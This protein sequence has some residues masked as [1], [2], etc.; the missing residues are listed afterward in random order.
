MTPE[1]VEDWVES[2]R[3]TARFHPW[4]I[5]RS[6]ASI[7]GF[8]KAAPHRSREAYRWSAEVSAYIDP[9]FH[10]RGVGSALYGVLIPL[11]RAQGYVTLLAG[12]T[13]GHEASERLHAK[14]GFVRCGT[15][16]RIGWKLDRWQDVG[17][18]ELHLTDPG[19]VPGPIRPV[20]EVRT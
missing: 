15:F 18:W 14:V 16:H 11:L 1:P 7:V 5:A 20:A 13:G 4:L 12:I 10:R 19:T 3:R 2:W 9:K 8:A 17:Y 6:G